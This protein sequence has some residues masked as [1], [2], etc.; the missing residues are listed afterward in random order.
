MAIIDAR[1]QQKRGSL[2]E[3]DKNKMLEGE[4]AI[5]NDSD[6]IFVCIAPGV[7][8]EIPSKQAMQTLLD[9]LNRVTEEGQQIIEDFEKLE[10]E[11]VGINDDEATSVTTFSSEKI[12]QMIDA[13]N[14]FAISIESELPTE[15]ID[16]H[17][18]YFIPKEGSE[19]G[20]VYDE[21]IFINNEWEHIGSTEIDL[22]NYYTTEQVDEIQRVADEK[23]EELQTEVDELNSNLTPEVLFEGSLTIT[24]TSTEILTN[25]IDYK[26]LDI[27]CECKGY[28][29]W[30]T[31]GVERLTYAY[32]ENI[33]ASTANYISFTF[34]TYNKTKLFVSLI[35]SSGTLGDVVIKKIIGRKV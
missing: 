33:F 2:A 25:I 3:L 35:T 34:N 19:S 20:D 27:F 17:T 8:L 15:N 7:V 6:S 31:I 1:M 5:P 29:K 14:E 10:V 23:I 16:T 12:M 21:Y 9:T 26:Y 22:S 18:I 24:T 30:T 4:F 32:V 13:I 11:K 28:S